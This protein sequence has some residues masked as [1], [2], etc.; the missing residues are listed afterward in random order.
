MG[1]KRRLTGY[2]GMRVDWPHIR[3]IESA[4]SFDFDSVLRGMVTGLSKPYLIRGFEIQIPDAAVAA[5]SL[6]VDVSDTAILHSSAG[7]SGTIMTIA[8]GTPAE[9][10]NSSNPKV[11]G[12]FQN[13]VPNY[14]GIALV[15][16]TDPN[17]T[18][19]T[20]GWSEAQKT[21]FQRTVPIGTTLDY[22]Y[23]ITTSGFSTNLPLYIVGVSATGAVE[24]IR[25]AR[26][27][28]FRLGT[29]GTVP[30]PFNSYNF[31]GLTNS[32]DPANPRREWI[33]ENPTVDPN[34][35]TAVPG[36]D[37]LAFRFG[38]FAIS[39]LK[40]WL[41]AIMTR[42]KEVTNSSYW[43][44]DSNVQNL[45]L[46]DLWW[47]TNSSVM[48]G[49]GNVSYN[50]ILEINEL[51]GGNLQ[52]QFTDPTILPGDSYV[53]GVTSGNKANLQAYNNTQ[54][55]I[56]SLQREDFVFDEVLRNRRV[57]RPNLANFELDDD[58]DVGASERV[59]IM[60]RLPTITGATTSISAWSYTANVITITT[61][62]PH[63]YSV[64]DYVDVSG[65]ESSTNELLPNGV[66]L[67]KNIVDSTNFQYTAQFTPT[68]VEAVTGGTDT[69]L[70]G[71]EIHP[72]LP[73]FS[74]T[75]WE[76]VG[77]DIYLTIPGHS[78]VSGDDIVVS[79]LTATTNAPNGRFLSVTVEPDNRV[80]YTGVALPTGTEG[81]SGALARFD[82]Y[83]F[84][85]TLQGALP[86]TY[87]TNNILATAWSDTQFSYTIGP[88]SLPA[89]AT[90]SG[91]ITVD[92]V[93]AT[94]TVANPVRVSRVD[95]D[96]TGRLTVTTNA[97][98]GYF[99]TPG[100]LTY[101]IYGNQSLSPYIRTY[102]DIGIET[103]SRT[104]STINKNGDAATT[105]LTILDNSF[106]GGEVVNINTVTFT[107]TTDW[108]V[109]GSASDTAIN[110]AAAI[111]G[112]VDIL[113]AGIVTAT[114]VG[115]TVVITADTVGESGNSIPTTISNEGATANLQF[116]TTTLAGG[117]SYLEVITTTDH[118]YYTGNS[119]QISG[120]AEGTFNGTFPISSIVNTTTFRVN[121]GGDGI[122]GP[123][124]GGTAL[125]LTQFIIDPIPPNGTTILPPPTSYINSGSDDVF[126][127][128][129]ENP[130]P[131]P[132]QWDS[133]IVIKGIIGDKYFR[134]PQTATANGTALSDGFNINGLTG[135]AYLQNGEV[136]YI[137]LERNKSVSS[138]STYSTSGTDTIIGAVPPVDEDSN[139]LKAGDFVKFESDSEAKWVRIAGTIGTDILTGT[140]QIESDNGQPPTV[141]QRPPATGRLL[142]SKTTYDEVTVQPHYLVPSSGNVFWIAARRD[143]D[144][145]KSKVYFRSLELEQGEIR[146]VNDNENSN[147]LIYTGART[148]AARNP[149]YSVIDD[150]GVYGPTQ[151]VVVGSNPEDIN[152]KTRTITFDGGP[153]LGFQ[154]EDLITFIDGGLPITY[155][156]NFLHSS[157]TVTVKEDIS[158]LS[159]GQTVTYIR[160]NYNVSDSDNLT[161]AARKSDREQSRVN[162]ALERPIYD[163]S[164]YIQQIDTAGAGTIKSGSFIYQGPEDSPT[165]LAWVIHGNAPVVEKI[166]SFNQEMPGGHVSIGPDSILVMIYSGS[167]SD[168]SAIFQNSVN[169]GRTVDNVGDPD[170]VSPAIPSGLKIVLP[171]NRRTQVQGSA[172]VV[173]P[174]MATYKASVDPRLS[175]EELLVISNDSIR[176]ASVDYEETFGGPK[177]I[178]EILRDMPPHTRM[179]FRIMPAFGS[180][181]AKLS[182]NISLQLAYNGGSSIITLSGSPVSIQAGDSITGGTGLDL[183]GSL[184]V[185][186]RGAVPTD[187]VG[188]IFG[189]RG[190][191]VDQAFLI[192]KESNKP[193]E[194]WAGTDLVKTHTGYTGSAW[195]RKTGSGV[196]S[197]S[198]AQTIANTLITVE[199][200]KS[201]RISI[202]VTGRRTDGPLG[203][204]S[205]KIEGTFYN[206][207][208]GVVA[209]GSPS[210]IH[211]GG[212]GD[213]NSYAISFGT[214]GDDVVLVVFGT[215]GSTIQ[216][217]TGMDYQ[218]IEGSA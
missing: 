191:D 213:G 141:D 162:T 117:F 29:G 44:T 173:W 113:I 201:A 123:G 50:L 11:I 175:G 9:A 170:F 58:I 73:S 104:I 150:G 15:R 136:A 27:N 215:S 161:L 56:N 47:D 159:L 134:I 160:S 149:N 100:P 165:A 166:E 127:R 25:N 186:G 96:G 154:A 138:G 164:V 69:R 78:F 157:R 169:T 72:F 23:V 102:T 77:T 37:P 189:P 40:E 57:W 106:D 24:Y 46:L 135:T 122:L 75:E 55:V 200:G 45:N 192:G 167:W 10:L 110:I 95:N 34:P 118:D 6:Q 19:Q 217:V 103:V 184:E 63:G 155:T 26:T 128:F 180:A 194:V 98:H 176:Q 81:V 188:G 92:G 125:N 174:A 4:V 171:P 115:N 80:K 209:A 87:E 83:E 13:G 39:S 16:V 218:I 67:V 101:T 126:A 79:G 17:S 82:S 145:A 28:L 105:T 42:F 207:G 182:G 120:N 163:E 193:K 94:T 3:S 108:A 48:T 140:F 142:Y 132:I 90:G 53:E 12:A 181:L 32:Q 62:A 60:K 22:R 124:A 119:I 91:A 41:D 74:I 76:Y 183:K 112:S 129:P 59:A 204:A 212:A 172:I 35:V 1:V 52:T 121:Y 179:R 130:Y 158:D 51:T 21:S 97:P 198:G 89:L 88:D 66:H 139:P 205:F 156:I 65:L 85:M 71:S 202:N 18:N 107:E 131:G 147:H 208:A 38:D 99:T 203:I 178:I 64:G 187:I 206:T 144:A 43:Y 33:N 93:V 216:W 114:P 14:V 190:P 54:L 199:S 84:L 210:T 143:N 68:G 36:D 116:A 111:N 61:S 146:E 5:N 20:S 196:S 197:G 137:E 185:D 109:G 133:D 7:E 177:G 152:V 2:S 30:N 214:V 211:F 148:E 153:E 151:D 168:T 8:N 70:D 86:D 31:D 195:T 49:A